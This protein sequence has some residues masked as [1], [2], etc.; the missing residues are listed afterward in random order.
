M[1]C[2]TSKEDKVAN[3]RSRQIDLRLRSEGEN[4]SKQVKLL[5]LGKKGCTGFFL[6]IHFTAIL[7]LDSH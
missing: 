2:L 5:L 6:K 4:A 7:H 1:G 3:Q